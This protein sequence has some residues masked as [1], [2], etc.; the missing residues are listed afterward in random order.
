MASPL[1]PSLSVVVPNYNHAEYVENCLL[2]ILRQS[3]QPL[4]VIVLDDASTDNSVEV[5]R[6][7]AAQNPV[8]RLVQNEKNLGVMPNI[9]KGIGLSRGEFVFVSSA[10]DEVVPGLFEKSLR[11]LAQHPQAGLSCTVCEWRYVDT[12]LTWHMGA[13]MGKNPCYLSP[14]DLVRLGKRDQLV[15]GTSSAIV[16][17]TALIQAGCFIPELRWHADWLAV[18]VPAFRHG[19]CFVP[20]PLSVFNIYSKSYYSSGHKLGEHRRVLL[21]LVELLSSPAYADARRGIR[22]SGALSLFATPM[23]RI[24]L[25]RPDYRSFINATYLRRTLRRSAEL[26]GKKILP[27]WLARWFLNRFYRART[28]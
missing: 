12:G 20:E 11:L 21:R 26:V 28:A 22:D 27:R 24:L 4:E 10:D 17:K 9:N 25:S 7:I 18:F 1:L 2:A 6:R 15:L 14:D 16:R 5:I 19:V 8:I 23:L 3:V 13:G